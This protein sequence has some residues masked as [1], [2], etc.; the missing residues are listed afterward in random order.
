MNIYPNMIPMP[1]QMFPVNQMM[2]GNMM[3][4]PST[5]NTQN[6]YGTSELSSISRQISSLEQRVSRLESIVGG[7]TY[8]TNYNPTNY[9][10]M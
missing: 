10:M 9:Q 5:T 2:P 1:N 8:S 6:N 7:S 3:G 4:M